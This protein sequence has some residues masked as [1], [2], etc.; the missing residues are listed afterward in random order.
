VNIGKPINENHPS[1]N[2][3]LD[4]FE[5]ARILTQVLE[6]E[7]K[8]NLIHVEDEQFFELFEKVKK[9]VIHEQQNLDGKVPE[10]NLKF[11]LSQEIQ[12]GL[13]FY[14]RKH[15]EVLMELS[16]MLDQYIERVDFYQVSDASIAK[17]QPYV[18]WRDYGKLVLGMPI[19]LLGYFTNFLPYHVTNWVFDKLKVEDQFRGSI[20]MTLGLVFFLVWYISLGIIIAN[21]FSGWWYG[22]IGVIAIFLLGRFTLRFLSLVN[23]LRQTGKLKRIFKRKRNVFE[24]LA[25]EREAIINFILTYSN[26]EI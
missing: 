6:D 8:D 2:G 1:I 15:P 9:V 26:R 3:D 13:S 24:Q 21:V 4:D 7:L 12:E 14:G 23:G 5:K 19:F 10:Q 22:L 18:R 16:R 11:K 17:G 25:E 20:G